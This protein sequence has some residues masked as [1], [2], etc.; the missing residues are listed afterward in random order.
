MSAH[1]GTLYP[2]VARA[3]RRGIQRVIWRMEF[4]VTAEG[5]VRGTRGFALG[6]RLLRTT[7]GGELRMGRITCEGGG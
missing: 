3:R 6:G 2:A 4:R 1:I 5:G 7:C